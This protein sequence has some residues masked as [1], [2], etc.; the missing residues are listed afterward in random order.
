[1]RVDRKELQELSKIR[2]KE[3]TALLELGLSDGAYYLEAVG[4]AC[5]VIATGAAGPGSAVAVEPKLGVERIVD[6]V[7][8]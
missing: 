6:L 3:A 7:V 8:P 1:M 4:G 5:E 2:L